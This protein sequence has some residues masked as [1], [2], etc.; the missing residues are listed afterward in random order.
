MIPAK[1]SPTVPIAVRIF[2]S[3]VRAKGGTPGIVTHSAWA[4][5]EEEAQTWLK[6][7]NQP[8]HRV[9]GRIEKIFGTWKRSYGLRRMRWRGTAKA[10]AQVHLTAIA[11]NL[12]RTLSIINA[13]VA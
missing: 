12:K 9:R 4:R 3:V 5:T 13:A 11:Y 8:I 10:T 1:S 7:L 6:A 2:G